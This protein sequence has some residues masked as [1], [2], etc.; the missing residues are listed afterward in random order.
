MQIGLRGG[1]FWRELA[2]SLAAGNY[3]LLIE[4]NADQDRNATSELSLDVAGAPSYLRQ[5]I[6]RNIVLLELQTDAPFY[7]DDDLNRQDS[8]LLTSLQRE[9]EGTAEAAEDAL[10]DITEGRFAVK[11]VEK[12]LR[13]AVLKMLPTF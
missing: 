2:D 7:S 1:R 10:P 5:L 8:S 13:V 12:S 4:A 9:L 6:S 11:V 3:T